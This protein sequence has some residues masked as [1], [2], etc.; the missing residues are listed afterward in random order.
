MALGALAFLAGFPQGLETGLQAP[1]NIAYRNALAQLAQEQM[2][3]AKTKALG[4]QLAGG[5]DLSSLFGSPLP[6]ALLPQAPT[7]GPAPSPGGTAPVTPV[8]QAAIPPIGV[9]PQGATVARDVASAPE[10]TPPVLPPAAAGT[11]QTGGGG[12]GS[13]I[14]SSGN[15]DLD[16]AMSEVV[17]QQELANPARIMELVKRSA[18]AQG[19]KADPAAVFSAT[20]Q[21][22]E[23]LNSGNRVNALYTMGMLRLMQQRD[24]A[25]QRE[26]GIQHRA[27]QRLEQQQRSLQERETHDREIEKYRAGQM[28]A[29]ERQR[30]VQEML[31]ELRV[32]QQDLGSIRSNTPNDT[33]GLADAKARVDE[34]RRALQGLGYGVP[35]PVPAAPVAPP[36]GA[37]AAPPPAQ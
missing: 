30:R 14:P 21:I 5:T 13:G 20:R 31:T 32:A 36:G 6:A 4:A 11:P 1:G 27:D 16:Q 12:I 23:T 33:A 10:N 19:I 29:T 7:A 26:T 2:Q 24:L 3:E 18:E 15:V 28:S 35:K 34:L 37:S 17:R 22:M 25:T 8:S 9:A